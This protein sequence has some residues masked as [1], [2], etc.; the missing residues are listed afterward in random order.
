MKLTK[1]PYDISGP[2]ISPDGNQIV[3]LGYKEHRQLFVMDRV[4]GNVHL[5]SDEYP[6][7]LEDYSFTDILVA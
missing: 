4:G 1:E 5:L 7:S 6:F 2:T 3:F